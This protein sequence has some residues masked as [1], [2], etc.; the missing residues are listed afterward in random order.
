MTFLLQVWFFFCFSWPK[1]AHLKLVEQLCDHL[2]RSHPAGDA[3]LGGGAKGRR[4]DGRLR[5]KWVREEQRG[6]WR[7]TGTTEGL[8]E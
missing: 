7:T 5:G 3:N 2:V 1:A 6:E 8:K 4:E